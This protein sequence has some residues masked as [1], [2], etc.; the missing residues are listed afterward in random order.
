MSCVYVELLIG[1]PTHSFLSIITLTHL[2]PF[3]FPTKQPCP[4]SQ[5][6]NQC[7]YVHIYL[8]SLPHMS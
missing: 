6:T 1:G 3:V 2:H 5:L 7:W 8:P 4:F